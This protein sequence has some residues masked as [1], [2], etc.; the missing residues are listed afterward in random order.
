M[1]THHAYLHD[2]LD[3]LAGLAAAAVEAH[4]QQDSEVVAVAKVF[5]RFRHEM[6]LHLAHEEGRVFPA[7]VTLCGPSASDAG[8]DAALLDWLDGLEAEHEYQSADLD[9]LR[10][11]TNGFMVREGTGLAYQ[12]LLEGLS[13]LERDTREHVRHENEALFL[14][15]RA[16]M[17]PGA[18]QVGVPPVGDR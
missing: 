16:L 5:D 18:L 1:A 11:M 10:E 8:P 9:K 14:M 6:E 13:D 7:I 12:T 17:V 4:R 15:V 2:N 3:R